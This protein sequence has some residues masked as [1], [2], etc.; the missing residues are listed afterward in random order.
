ML[1]WEG[2]VYIVLF[3]CQF[4]T[5]WHKIKHKH[6]AAVTQTWFKLSHYQS[7]GQLFVQLWGARTLSRNSKT[8]R[9][10][11]LVHWEKPQHI[12]R[13][14]RGYKTPTPACRLSQ[15]E[16]PDWNRVHPVSRRLVPELEYTLTL[17]HVTFHIH[18]DSLTSRGSNRQCPRPWWPQTHIRPEGYQCG[19]DL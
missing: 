18:I 19:S 3:K 6:I 10:N 8:Q 13:K 1:G 4:L 9:N 17:V 7:Q 2:L 12:G 15:R 11:P 5:V 14:S 16:T